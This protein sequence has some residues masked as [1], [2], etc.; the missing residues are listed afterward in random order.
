MKRRYWIGVGLGVLAAAGIGLGLWLTPAWAGSKRPILVGLLHSL[1]GPMAISEKS[2]VQ[3]EKL[4]IAELNAAGGIGGRRIEAI[5]ADGESDPQ[6]FARQAQTLIDRGVSVIVGCWS[7]SCRKSVLPVVEK[8]D[9]FLI[10][11]VAYEGMEQSPNIF[12]TGAA[13]N[14]QV[15]P[16]VKWAFDVLKARRFYLIGTDTIWPRS[17]N[18]I[19]KDQLKALGGIVAGEEYFSLGTTTLDAAV[20]RAIKAKPDVI[21]STIEGDANLPFYKKIRAPGSEAVKIPIIS[22]PLTE[23]EL[24]E[25]PVAN[26]VNDYCV[27]NYFQAIQRQENKTFIAAFQAAYGADRS[28]SDAVATAFSSVKLWA[29]AVAEADTDEPRIARASMLRQS[30]NAP[31]GVI[32]IDRESQH[33]WRPFFVGRV[34]GDGQV[35]IVFSLKKPI[36][37]SPFPFSRTHAQWGRFLDDLYREWGGHWIPPANMA[38]PSPPA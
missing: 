13:P 10:Y 37:P 27:C 23:E 4:A 18:T 9:H 7:S 22:Y 5:V 6:V 19:I 1:T 29:Q 28:T 20:D 33:T 15:I 11:P 38:R 16:T 34:Q 25:L 30:L 26:M 12:Y 21:L 35:E 31:E 24:R 3:A 36:R 32:S 14:Q 17:V 8:A 2:M